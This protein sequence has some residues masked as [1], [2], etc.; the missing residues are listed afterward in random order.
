MEEINETYINKS[1]NKS[2]Y[3]KFIIGIVIYMN[4]NIGN[5]LTNYAL[6]QFLKDM[7][8]DLRVINTP[9]NTPFSIYH[10]Y[11]EFD[12]FIN[13]PYSNEDLVAQCENKYELMNLNDD[14]DCFVLGSDQLLRKEFIEGTD[15]YVCMDWVRSDKFKFSY[16]TS[17]GKSDFDGDSKMLSKTKY[18]LNRFQ[19]ISVREKSGVTLLYD[20]FGLSSEFVLDPV[21]LCD[22]K[23]YEEMANCGIGRIPSQP[24]VGAYILDVTEE[25]ETIVSD[26]SKVISNGKHLLILNPEKYD[27][28]EYSGELESLGKPK[29]EEWLAL[30]KECDFFI[31]DS[32]HGLCF[33]LLFHKQFC[34]IT[35]PDCWRGFTRISSLLK[36]LNL[37]GRVVYNRDDAIKKECW[38]CAIDY[39]V[40]NV[41]LAGEIFK[42]KKWLINTVESCGEYVGQYTLFDC[43]MECE[44][45]MHERQKE[46]EKREYES[47]KESEKQECERLAQMC[48]IRNELYLMNR[49]KCMKRV[50]VRSMDNMQIVAWGAG[51]CFR[52]NIERIRKFYNLKWVCDNNPDKWGQEVYPG[53]KCIS[54][55]KLNDMRDVCVII[56]IDS[57][58]IGFQ[59]ASQLIDMNIATFD[60]VENWLKYVEE[61]KRFGE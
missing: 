33:A 13:N 2:H 45:T 24:F 51:D 4:H 12:L 14:C 50:N 60:H 54:P 55:A 3:L 28:E 27:A 46:V 31:T 10:L 34:I 16:G 53:I 19:A 9:R 21:F 22:M 41:I 8:Y 49:K 30:I 7:N 47:L 1:D 36:M 57:A 17:F 59:V 58:P 32:F 56:M 23:H 37:E 25:R 26:F 6:Y 42:S 61:G 20:K 18:L 43:L 11:K 15:Y 44:K 5:N 39:E 35:D 40:V 29:V 38:K 52:R 48:H